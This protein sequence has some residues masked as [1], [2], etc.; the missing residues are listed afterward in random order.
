MSD[1]LLAQSPILSSSEKTYGAW[2]LAVSASNTTELK[3][4]DFDFN[5]LEYPIVMI[6]P[7]LNWIGDLASESHYV[8]MMFNTY[9]VFESTYTDELEARFYSFYQPFN[10]FYLAEFNEAENLNS[11]YYTYMRLGYSGSN[12][13]FNIIKDFAIYS[14]NTP[15][16]GDIGQLSLYILGLKQS[17]FIG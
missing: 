3:V 2:T 15:I 1:A 12:Y 16:T 10:A 13:E 14:N 8:K 5:P 7:K 11:R 17:F 6:F 4:T 9:N